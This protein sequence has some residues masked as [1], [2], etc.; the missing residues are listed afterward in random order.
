MSFY[1]SSSGISG[2]ENLVKF[3][4]P[5]DPIFLRDLNEGKGV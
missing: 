3:S 4:A 2:D 1:D 5:S